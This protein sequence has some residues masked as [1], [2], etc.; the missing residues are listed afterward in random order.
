MPSTPKFAGAMSKETLQGLID[1][2]NA[3]VEDPKL[4]PNPDGPS[5]ASVN[6]ILEFLKKDHSPKSS[7]APAVMYQIFKFLLEELKHR[8]TFAA[9]F[10]GDVLLLKP[11]LGTKEGEMQTTRSELLYTMTPPTR[12]AVFAFL[13]M[14]ALVQDSWDIEVGQL[15]ELSEE[16][17]KHFAVP[18]VS[19]RTCLVH[20][21]W[22]PEILK[23][24][25]AS[26]FPF[27]CDLKHV[28][29]RIL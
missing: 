10:N 5:F 11:E 6:E 18:I 2:T 13:N 17:R 12:E 1:Q 4:V 23:L 16:Q 9:K 14:T 8:V 29:Q 15:S 25:S 21:L 20:L 3:T 27:Q 26:Q 19:E 24:R 28:L 22:Q 7:V